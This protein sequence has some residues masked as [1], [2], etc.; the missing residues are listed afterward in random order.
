MKKARKIRR[1]KSL[2]WTIVPKQVTTTNCSNPHFWPKKLQLELLIRI[3]TQA[4]KP[5]NR[6]WKQKDTKNSVTGTLYS[7]QS[8]KTWQLHRSCPPLTKPKN[9]LKLICLKLVSLNFMAE[10]KLLEM[11][12]V[13][14]HKQ[15]KYRGNQ[16]HFS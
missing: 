2:L 9:Q 4:H 13:W 1:K 15:I 3:K 10:C 16:F 11:I 8:S 5:I 14:V 6:F 7:L 12:L